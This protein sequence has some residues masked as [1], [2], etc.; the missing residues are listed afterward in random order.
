MKIYDIPCNFRVQAKTEGQA[1]QQVIKFL[2]LGMDLYDVEN[3]VLGWEFFDFVG[4]EHDIGCGTLF[5]CG[6]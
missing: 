1:E 4:E 2:K 3:G 5:G 6:N